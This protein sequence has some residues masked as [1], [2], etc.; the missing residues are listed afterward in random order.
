MKKTNPENLYVSKLLLLL[1]HN[2]SLFQNKDLNFI[3]GLTSTEVSNAKKY[4]FAN[5]L[6]S[7]VKHGVILSDSGL[8]FIDENRFRPWADSENPYRP[9]INLEYLK[10]PEHPPALTKAIR[11]LADYLLANKELKP[12]STEANIYKEIFME[13]SSCDKLRL[14]AIDFILQ[15]KRIKLS[16]FYKKFTSKPYGLT[17][18]LTFILLL[19]AL[20]NSKEKLAI[21]ENFEFQLKLDTN[22]Y[23]RMFY[24]PQRFEVQKTVVSEIPVLYEISKTILRKPCK[25]IL[26]LT[27]GIIWAVKSLDNYTITTK[28]LHTTTLQLRNAVINTKDPIN[29]VLK[30]I[31][32][33]L[34]RKPIEQCGNDFV[35]KFDL[36]IKEL[37]NNY[38]LLI[39]ELRNFFF[40]AFETGNRMNIAQRFRAVEEYLYEKNLKVLSK[41]VIEKNSTDDLW[42]ER[43]ATFINGKRV[44]K[45]WSDDDVAEY[46]LKIKE[47]AQKF[48]TIEATAGFGDYKMDITMQDVLSQLLNLEKSKQMAVIRKAI[49]E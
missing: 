30:D 1:K 40:Y 13:K 23:F 4:I 21:Y 41:N 31:P 33:I 18:S 49:N 3:A 5:N 36:C 35:E 28:N 32:N 7:R 43:I 11:C 9:D 27:K 45:D 22:M 46:K 14:E 42:I 16:H 39:L 37:Q 26:T 29:L 8:K 19:Y 34:E 44:P 17:K 20:V 38:S 10:L 25:N 12:Y 24:A 15:P 2:P 6:A 47:Y 48:L